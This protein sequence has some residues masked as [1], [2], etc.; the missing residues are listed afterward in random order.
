[1]PRNPSPFSL[2]EPSMISDDDVAKAAERLLADV[3]K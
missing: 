2:R 3:K 1:M